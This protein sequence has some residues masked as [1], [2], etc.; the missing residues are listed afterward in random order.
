MYDEPDV[1]SVDAHSE[2]H[3]R[4]DDLDALVEEGILM[5]LA[6]LIRKPGVVGQGRGAGFGEPRRERI[7]LLSR[8]AVDD[9]GFAV[10]PLEDVEE[11]TLQQRSREDAVEEVRPIEGANQ[12]DRI[13]AARV[14]CRCRGARA[15]SPSRCRRG[16]RC[17]AEA[18][19]VDRA[20][21]TP[22]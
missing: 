7:D 16:L 21:D 9:T 14:A 15:Q 13:A 22:A 20:D 12:L 1:G 19:A 11:L 2:C 6:L 10:V 4:H 18:G 8:R 5:R 17:Q 3:G